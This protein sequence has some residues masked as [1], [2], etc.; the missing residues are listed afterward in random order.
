MKNQ[1][2]QW[3][4]LALPFFLVI[5][6]APAF[7]SAEARVVVDLGEAAPLTQRIEA[8]P[9]ALELSPVQVARTDEGLAGQDLTTLT[10]TL[11]AVAG[12][13][14]SPEG[15]TLEAWILEPGNETLR[16]LEVLS[17]ETQGV[18][19]ATLALRVAEIIRA[20]LIFVLVGLAEDPVGDSD[21]AG[22]LVV[23]SDGQFLWS[24]HAA[25]DT[26]EILAARAENHEGDLIAGG[27]TSSYGA[28]QSDT[29]FIWFSQTGEELSRSS[30]G[31]GYRDI[32]T[33]SVR[34]PDGNV[35]FIGSIEYPHNPRMGHDLLII[36][37]V[38]FDRRLRSE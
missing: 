21:D 38:G 36:K 11:D 19:E 33:E 31:T 24:R 16:R 35:Y 23:D 5:M 32:V 9:R 27:H 1:R 8:E 29:L 14:V 12:V 18:D 15:S 3:A 28:S 34:D 2:S 26:S 6:L 22:I 4:H 13:A 17:S 20:G 7:A 30:L 10:I 37:S 25:G